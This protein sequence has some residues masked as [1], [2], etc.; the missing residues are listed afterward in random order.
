[1]KELLVAIPTKNREDIMPTV[2]QSLFHQTTDC[3]NL[4]IYDEGNIPITENYHVRQFFDLLEIHKGIEITHRRNM[5]DGSLARARIFILNYTKQHNY[6]YVMMLD[7]DV[8]LTPNTIEIQLRLDT[9]SFYVFY[10]FHC[11]SF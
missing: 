2:L 10:T 9:R 5:K 3:F 6:K 4:L 8:M 1:M 11:N 7:D